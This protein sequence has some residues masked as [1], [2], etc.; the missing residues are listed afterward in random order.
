MKSG[1]H[2]NLVEQSISIMHLLL[3]SIFLIKR[4]GLIVLVETQF[5][6]SL[7]TQNTIIMKKLKGKNNNKTNVNK[8]SRM[9][10]K[11]NFP[12]LPSLQATAD[13]YKLNTR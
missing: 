10:A 11:W 13:A 12:I 8:T 5:D 1:L 3:Y 2:M 7:K 9:T 4:Y 6:L